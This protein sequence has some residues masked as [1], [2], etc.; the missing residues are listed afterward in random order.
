MQV[1]QAMMLD[2]NCAQKNAFSVSVEIVTTPLA[3]SDHYLI[4]T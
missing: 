2:P 4:I 3:K 1:K